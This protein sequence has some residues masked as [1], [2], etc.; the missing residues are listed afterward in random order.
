MPFL[1]MVALPKRDALRH[2]LSW[3]LRQLLQNSQQFNPKG[4]EPSAAKLG[5][6]KL[7]PLVGEIAWA[8]IT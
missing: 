7:Q 8:Q 2:E 6:A 1:Y 3:T 5:D 4:Q